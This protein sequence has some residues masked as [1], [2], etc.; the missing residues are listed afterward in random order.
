M[1]TKRCVCICVCVF[2]APYYNKRGGNNI[3]LELTDM[4]VFMGTH[5]CYI[6]AGIIT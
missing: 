4:F 3:H 2:V 6:I 1:A 5:V